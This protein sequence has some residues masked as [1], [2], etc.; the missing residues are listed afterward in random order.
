MAWEYPTRLKLHLSYLKHQENLAKL[1]QKL[2]WGEEFSYEEHK[3]Q[4]RRQHL[5]ASKIEKSK[6]QN[7]LYDSIVERSTPI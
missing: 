4:V 6:K 3:S 7:E 2:Y 1:L 5:N